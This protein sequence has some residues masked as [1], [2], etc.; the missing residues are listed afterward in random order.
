M[1]I[2]KILKIV[3]WLI[4]VPDG[5]KD[6]ANE[7]FDSSIFPITFDNVTT[8]WRLAYNLNCGEY[9]LKFI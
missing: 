5:L 9:L 6:F 7:E 3:E 4:E 1:S 2:T 8:Y